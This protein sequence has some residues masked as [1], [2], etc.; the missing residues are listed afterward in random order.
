MRSWRVEWEGVIL[1]SEI[2]KGLSV[3]V[4]APLLHRR[5][6]RWILQLLWDFLQEKIVSGANVRYTIS[7]STALSLAIV[8]YGIFHSLLSFSRSHISPFHWLRRWNSPCFANPRAKRL[9]SSACA[10]SPSSPSTTSIRTKSKVTWW[11]TSSRTQA[12]RSSTSSTW[13]KSGRKSLT[14]RTRRNSRGLE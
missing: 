4:N 10:A 7:L 8:S 6:V 2:E 12:R 9:R 11:A 14:R 5:M 3:L 1:K 13:T